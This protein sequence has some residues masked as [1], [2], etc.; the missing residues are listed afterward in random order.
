MTSRATRP[1]SRLSSAMISQGRRIWD[2]PLVSKVPPS[3]G[4]SRTP[5]PSHNR[6]DCGGTLGTRTPRARSS[7][8][9]GTPG[10]MSTRMETAS[11]SS[12]RRCSDCSAVLSGRPYRASLILAPAHAFETDVQLRR[13]TLCSEDEDSHSLSPPPWSVIIPGDHIEREAALPGMTDHPHILFPSVPGAEG[14]TTHGGCDVDDH[15]PSGEAEVRLGGN[16]LFPP[17]P[18]SPRSS[19]E[20]SPR[21]EPITD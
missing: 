9:T 15:S 4:I 16:V 18:F 12:R 11:I 7:G 6:N 13:P 1:V 5:Y 3:F 20:T 8:S 19:T 10:G 17:C 14:Q 21:Q 2:P